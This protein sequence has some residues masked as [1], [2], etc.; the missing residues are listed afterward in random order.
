MATE[1]GRG[2]F[3]AAEGHHD[4]LH[5]CDGILE[6]IALKAINLAQH[7]YWLTPEQLR[8]NPFD[9]AEIN[10]RLDQDKQSFLEKYELTPKSTGA[11]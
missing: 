5:Q 6:Q 2:D 7:N 10:K 4:I 9:Q 8:H 3:E 11:H 1:I